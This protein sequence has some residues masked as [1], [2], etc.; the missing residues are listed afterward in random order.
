MAPLKYEEKLKDKL[1]KR[2]LQPSENAWEKLSSRLDTQEKKNS[3]PYWWL[4]FAASIVG[5]LFVV[6]Q[7]L[8]I[9]TKS[10]EE[11]KVVKTPKVIQQNQ[12]IKIASENPEKESLK[13]VKDEVEAVNKKVIIEGTEVKKLLKSNSANDTKIAASRENESLNENDLKIEEIE[14]PIKALTFEEQKI[15]DVVAQVQALKSNNKEVTDA[16]IDA[17]LKQAQQEIKLYRLVNETS[18]VVDAN[19]LLQDVE[20]ELDQSFRN[21]VFEAIRLSY[22]S[23]KTAVAQRND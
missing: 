16:S 19:L 13:I 4:G 3:K 23:V 8:N 6:S 11:I 20:A 21:K 10:S 5:I 9:E 15:Q 18:G 22:K 7:F 17:L 2:T 1:E 14:T 12:T